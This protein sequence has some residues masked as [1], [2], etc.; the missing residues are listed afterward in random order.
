M[1]QGERKKGKKNEAH[2]NILLII[3]EEEYF[4]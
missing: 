4:V 3:K 2:K 1:G